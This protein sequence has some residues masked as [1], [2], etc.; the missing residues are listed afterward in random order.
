GQGRPRR[1]FSA[2]EAPRNARGK[3]SACS[4]NQQP[5]L[6]EPNNK[7]KAGRPAFLFSLKGL[8]K[9]SKGIFI[10]TLIFC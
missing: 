9:F 10:Y 3:R 6:T 7:K 2:E 5:S 8:E 4:E 1:R